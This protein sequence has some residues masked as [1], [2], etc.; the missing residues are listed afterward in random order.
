M[1]LESIVVLGI[2]S[3]GSWTIQDGG[4]YQSEMCAG[5]DCYGFK[6]NQSEITLDSPHDKLM[7]MLSKDA[8]NSNYYWQ[9]VAFQENA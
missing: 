9:Q 6:L 7:V 4:E 2:Y 3:G 1:D 5:Q 8:Y